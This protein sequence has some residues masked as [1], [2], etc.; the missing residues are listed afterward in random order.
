MSIPVPNLDDRDFSDLVAEAI[1][2]VR[3]VDPEWTDLSV[4]D[5][6][7]VLIEAFAHLTDILLYRLNRVPDRLYATFLN[8]L[9]ATVGPPGAAT[10][11]LDFSRVAPGG[12]QLRIPRG[13]RVTCP[14]AAPGVPL[15]VFVTLADAVLAEGQGSVQV[16]AADVVLHDAVALGVGTGGP[17][18]SFVLPEAPVVGSPGV[19]I[20]VQVPA[21]ETLTSGQAVVVDGL[22]FLGFREVNVFA[23]AR[24]G[25]GVYVLDRSAGI[26]TFG[27][28]ARGARVP[29][30]GM[31]VRAWYRT[32]GGARGNVA[33]G[34][35]SVLRD[36]ITGVK[37]TNP[38]PAS[39]GRD[40][41]PLAA[42]L[43][44]GPQE[45]QARD[46]AVTARDYEV[47]ATRHGGVERASAVTR[48]EAWAFA[49]PGEVEVVLVPHVPL[50]QRPEGRV[51]LA[52]LAAHAREQVRAEVANHLAGRA[53]IGAVP[54][55]GWC[56]Y[57][58][59]T[60][61]ARVVVR[62]DENPE[63]VRSR[64]LAR[65][66]DTIT[67]M[68]NPA[69]D[70][71]AGFGHPL[72]VSNLYRALEQAE[73]GVRYVERLRLE[74]AEVPDTD[75]S[76]LVRAEGQPDTWFVGQGPTVFRTTN[77]GDGWE[78]CATFADETVQAIAPW[79]ATSAGGDAA[80]PRP[81]FVAVAT[82]AGDGGR[83][84]VSTDLGGSWQQV[85]ELGFGIAALA[86]LDRA[87]VA[88]VLAA[89]E[90]G[91]YEIPLS[92]GA[93]P[94]QNLVD[95]QQPDRGFQAMATFVD[96]RGRV[97]VAVA[98]EAAGG[99]W[100]SATGG[101]PESFRMVRAAGE[102]IRSLSVQYDGATVFLWAPRAAP[103]GEGSGCIRLAIDELGRVDAPTL[104][105]R[106]EEL[107]AGWTGG[108]CWG[109][110]VVGGLAHAASQSSGVLTLQL[111][112]PGATWQQPDV[113]CGL[114]LRDRRRFKP[115]S[116]VSG[117]LG[118]DGEPYLLAAGAGGVHRSRSPGTGE[119]MT[120]QSCASRVVDDVV[121]IPPS[122]LFCSGE[123][124]VEV[125]HDG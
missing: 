19:G 56:Q 89:G 70:T 32:G 67:P 75:A 60:V 17:A 38:A 20:G 69:V 44:R 86:W 58:Q 121:T 6:G 59:V 37:V 11:T 102:E 111:G 23:D 116:S 79:P 51:T 49:E 66:A 8:L 46:R 107:S 120:W 112:T 9:G 80:R 73:P 113:N 125:V 74:L 33:A 34:A 65:L 22:A 87:G 55:V 108:S 14:P 81:G 1:A 97:G 76:D 64:I 25:E 5:P 24:P 29:G 2:R 35:L 39:G 118:E 93:V 119:A 122:W 43:R 40:A 104:A 26:L 98:A 77:A 92:P 7:V 30:A 101:A 117:V 123:H 63:A 48:R 90:K 94:V 3:Q 88:T 31:Q 15:P 68:P 57:K 62:P 41:E 115:I 52:A 85:A 82:D 47:L 83:I 61:D 105:G 10:V 21:S 50:D 95:A 28:G 100:L 72:R 91:L 106:W 4:H 124:R 16:E 114:P 103:E 53:A 96:L 18:Q 71:G 42:A 78:A 54:V 110:Q 36:P 99:L 13:T 27:D 45:F 84:H 12:P 109:V